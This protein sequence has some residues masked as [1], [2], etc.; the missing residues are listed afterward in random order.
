[1]GLFR[2]Q[3]KSGDST[4]RHNQGSEPIPTLIS[5]MLAAEMLSYQQ[6]GRRG[7]VAH[8]STELARGHRPSGREADKN[9]EAKMG[10]KPES[11]VDVMGWGGGL[12]DPRARD[13]PSVP[14]P[15]EVLIAVYFRNV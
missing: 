5:G 10:K 15:S 2:W 3:H 9:E 13:L 6:E 1:M 14:L 4:I 7:V 11:S 8:C 12:G